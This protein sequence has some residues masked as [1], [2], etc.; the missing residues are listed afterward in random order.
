MQLTGDKM[1][2][3]NIENIKKELEYQNRIIAEKDKKIDELNNLVSQKSKDINVLNISFKNVQARM[4]EILEIAEN[5]KENVK[6]SHEYFKNSL[7]GILQHITEMLKLIICETE[8]NTNRRNSCDILIINNILEKIF[9]LNEYIEDAIL[10]VKKEGADQ[11]I[12]KRLKEI[13][14]KN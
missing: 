10:N 4:Q 7:V 12:F 9:L 3:D 2:I 11:N 1:N 6:A 8:T 5:S 14:G 13:F